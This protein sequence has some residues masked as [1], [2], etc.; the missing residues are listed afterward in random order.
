MYTESNLPILPPLYSNGV[1]QN[2]NARATR[3]TVHLLSLGID[4]EAAL[5]INDEV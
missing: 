2:Y 4:E 3:T 1:N 5:V